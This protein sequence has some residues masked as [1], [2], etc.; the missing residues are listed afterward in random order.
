MA[1]A[2]H[3]E[4][5]E[6]GNGDVGE[7]IEHHFGKHTLRQLR[8]LIDADPSTQH[9]L[10]CRQ[11]ML[12]WDRKTVT[13]QKERQIFRV[14]LLCHLCSQAADHFPDDG[15]NTLMDIDIFDRLL[16]EAKGI[17]GVKYMERCIERVRDRH[18]FIQ[19]RDN[20]KGDT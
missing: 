8:G 2:P 5:E 7:N 20:V 10:F 13:V 19:C 16:D 12:A 3:C 14:S 11:I 18:I 17:P 15:V 6:Q 1:S 9:Q 4:K